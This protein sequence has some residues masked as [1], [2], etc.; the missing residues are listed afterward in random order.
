VVRPAQTS[1]LSGLIM[2]ASLIGQVLGVAAFAGIYLG[3][4]ANGPGHAMALSTAAIG[5]ALVATTICARVALSMHA[6]RAD[7][8]ASVE[9]RAGSR[10]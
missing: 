10:G 1:D 5:I 6:R 2:T 8:S 4:A 3:D 7:T 9:A